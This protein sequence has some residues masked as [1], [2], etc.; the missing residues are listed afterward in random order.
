M[1]FKP[2][3]YQQFCIQFIIDKAKA[4]LLLDMGLGKTASTLMAL[5]ILESH[6]LEIDKVL[7]IA[8]KRVAQY[9]W[10]NEIEKWDEFK[11]MSYSVIIG[12]EQ[13]RLK[14][15][16]KKAMIYLVNRENIEWLYTYLSKTK[17][18]RR[19]DTIILDE[20]SSFKNPSTKRFK[21]LKKMAIRCPRLLILTGTPAPNGLMDL[22]SQIYLLDQGQRLG[23]TLT[24]YRNRYFNPGRRNG[25]VIFD[26]VPKPD[27]EED[28]Y[29]A[30]SDIVVSMK[31]VDHLKMPERIDNNI[32]LEMSDKVKRIY[33]DF[34]KDFIL[35]LD[36]DVI[37]AATAGVLCNK[38]LQL[39]N[40]A[41]YKS[42]GSYEV[43]HNF[44]LEALEEILENNPEVPILVF[45]NYKSDLA[46]LKEYFEHIAPKTLD[47]PNA[48]DDWNNKKIR[49]LLA[50]PAS[51]GH[52][53]N[54]QAGG[55]IIVWFGLTF[56]LE[57]YQ[58]ANARLYRQGQK[59][60]VVIHHLIVKDS[61]DE[62]VM[63]SLQKK[64]HI[65]NSLIDY[66]KA[67]IRRIK[68]DGKVN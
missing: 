32:E 59:N 19:F 20:S 63:E 25:H 68:K 47:G 22:W 49:L 52:G 34:K 51:M 15:L 50:N 64:D 30:I 23:R 61:E 18:E 17:D 35:E 36:D 55:N 48:L 6:Y 8:P 43:I 41:L 62:I 60:T 53:L 5:K 24:E 7:I 10:P 56:N 29:R 1:K 44:K 26:W 3:E 42:D 2:H 37:T 16:E 65:Q 45:Y 38:L 57:L 66:V 11:K 33:D 31:S 27:A 9:T 67:E 14:A 21:A 46:R 12:T 39:S 4:G 58:Q 28:I 54:M 40:G 13:Q